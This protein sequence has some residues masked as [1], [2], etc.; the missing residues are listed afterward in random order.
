VLYKKSSVPLPPQLDNG[1]ID[2]STGKKKINIFFQK[3]FASKKSCLSL[4]SRLTIRGLEIA[5][6]KVD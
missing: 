6:E 3:V 1:L 5:R 4:R 2:A